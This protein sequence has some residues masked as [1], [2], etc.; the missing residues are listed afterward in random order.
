MQDDQLGEAEEHFV[1]AISLHHK[2]S[3]IAGEA[4]NL[5]ELVYLQ[6]RMGRREELSRHSFCTTSSR[7]MGRR[8][9][10]NSFRKLRHITSLSLSRRVKVVRT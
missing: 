4:P 10:W 5:Q 2:A 6:R 1:Q 8:T 7:L 3:D 9:V